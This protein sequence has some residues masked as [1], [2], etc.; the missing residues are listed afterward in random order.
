MKFNYRGLDCFYN[1]NDFG[2]PHT[3]VL[4][5]GFGGSSADWE[6]FVNVVNG[7]VNTLVLDQPGCG[8]SDFTS[9]DYFYTFEGL[10][11]LIAELTE[12]L[13]IRSTILCG[14]SAGGRLVY[15]VTAHK[16]VKSQMGFIAISTTPGIPIES[17]RQ[18]RREGD[19]HH[20]KMI[21]EHGIEAWVVNWLNL[22]L[23]AGLKVMSKE[24]NEE[25]RLRRLK[26]NTEVLQKYLLHSGLGIMEPLQDLLRETEIPGML[27]SGGD[28]PKYCEI[29]SRVIRLNKRFNHF[30]IEGAGHTLYLEKP[31]ETFS[32]INNFLT[33]LN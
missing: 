33:Q 2:T 15:Y 14:Y 24:F 22:D 1:Y 12:F 9:D 20:A 26:N 17:I 13:K 28:D 29:G 11:E 4:I 7:R 5:H 31:E 8:Q 25:Y 19:I 23:F 6:P 32:L 27:V 16:L 21:A 18:E 10:G 30:V 3:L